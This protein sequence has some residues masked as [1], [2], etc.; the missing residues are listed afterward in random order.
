MLDIYCERLGPG[1]WAEPVNAL[2]NLAFFGAAFLVWQLA[3]QR[4]LLITQAWLLIL[5][6]VGIGIGSGLFHTFAASW[7]RL[8]DELSILVFQLVYLWMY[9]RRIIGLRLVLAAGPVLALLLA[10]LAA[11][12]FAHLLNGSL[13][14]A[15]ALVVLIGLAIY[16]YRQ[17][18]TERGIMLLALLVFAV[19]LLFRSIDLLLCE[20]VALGT[21][22]L[23]HLLNGLV[24]YLVTRALLLN[25][26]SNR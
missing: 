19:S 6:I 13:G 21:H 3:K 25:G 12:Q 4:G 26:F 18:Q 20:S 10:T 5:L 22:F 15:P 17:A 8:L 7:A 2:T 23:W 1:L 14:Y 11:T 9:G 24:L 16:H